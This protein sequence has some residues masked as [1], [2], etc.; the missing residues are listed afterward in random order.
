MCSV[1]LRWVHHAT[2]QPGYTHI[3]LGYVMR[4]SVKLNGFVGGIYAPAFFSCMV[5]SFQSFFMRS[6]SDIQRSACSWGGICALSATRSNSN[7][8]CPTD[9]LP[10]SL[11]VCECRVG[12]SV[13]L[14]ELLDLAGCSGN[15]CC[16]RRTG[17]RGTHHLDGRVESV[18]KCER[19]GESFPS[20][21][22]E[23]PMGSGDDGGDGTGRRSSL[24]WAVLAVKRKSFD[25]DTDH[26]R[27]GAQ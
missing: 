4:P 12:D 24:R 14:A 15:G 13:S 20:R 22:L 19:N 21:D 8:L 10:A 5:S 9:L 23:L 16:A 25:C 7:A 11:H 2:D 18:E 3:N 1:R 27:N 17:D 26:T 6:L